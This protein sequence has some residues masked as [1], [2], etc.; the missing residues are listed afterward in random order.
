MATSNGEFRP[1]LRPHLRQ[2][3]G[4]GGGAEALEDLAG[5]GLKLAHAEF[6]PYRRPWR[7]PLGGQLPVMRTTKRQANVAMEGILTKEKGRVIPAPTCVACLGGSPSVARM[8]SLVAKATPRLK[9][10]G[11]DVHFALAN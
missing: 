4:F 9:S 10:I 11:M 8:L 2:R 3:L 6:R 7:E 1:G 5:P